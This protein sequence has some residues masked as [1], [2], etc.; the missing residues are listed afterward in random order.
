LKKI[1]LFFLIVLTLNATDLTIEVKKK[2][3]ILPSIA[4]EDSST[5]LDDTMKIR[6]F[7]SIFADLNVL[8]L[9]NVDRHRIIIDYNA[10]SV[11]VENK[12]FDFVL[13]Y[14]LFE[15]DSHKLNC[16]VKLLQDDEA[17]MIKNYKISNKKAFV[18]V[19][20]AIA[21]DINKYMGSDDIGWIKKK[22]VFAKITA[23]KQSEIVVADYTLSYQHT[24]IKGGFNIFPKWASDN[25]NGIY[26]TT[27][28]NS[29]PT[30][31]YLNIKNAKIKTIASSDGMIVCS[32]TNKNGSKILVTMAPNGQRCIQTGISPPQFVHKEVK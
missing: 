32:D 31:K 15:D 4:I 23:P 10:S 18:F 13:R 17:K 2:V 20:H 9:F 21:Y 30:L 24:I 16:S 7:K 12:D 3:D 25:Q 22:V 19:S 29:K 8:S 11:A 14:K 27:I 1:F 26:Y 28:N 5:N 6:F